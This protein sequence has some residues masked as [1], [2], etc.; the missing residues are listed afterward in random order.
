[1]L[2]IRKHLHFRFVINLFATSA[3]T[4][5]VVQSKIGVVG[6]EI[7]LVVS[8]KRFVVAVVGVMAVVSQKSF[9]A[10]VICIAIR[11]YERVNGWR[12]LIRRDR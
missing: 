3:E 2:S 6:V 9:V 4:R 12:W 10:S 1:M 5:W 8:G 11:R 7:P